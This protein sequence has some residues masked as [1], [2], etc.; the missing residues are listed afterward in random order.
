MDLETRLRSYYQAWC[1]RDLDAIVSCFTPTA[2]F[3]D[4]AFAARFEGLDQIRG[5]AK[6]TYAGAPDFHIDATRI[7]AGDGAGAAA[8][9][10]SGTH[11]GD[12]P[13]L[14][15]TNRRC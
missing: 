7:I 4:L 5:F 3:E 13:G 12:Y 10:M 11:S 9:T 2:T 14:P 15:A 8:W 1:D 6:L